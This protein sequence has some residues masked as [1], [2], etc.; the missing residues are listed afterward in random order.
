[1]MPLRQVMAEISRL[2]NARIVWLSGEGQEEQ[3]SV[4]FTDLPLVEG[5]QRILQQK[6]FILFYE[7]RSTGA[8]VTQIW[9]SSDRNAAQPQVPQEAP[10][11]VSPLKRAETGT[12]QNGPATASDGTVMQSVM[13]MGLS[14]PDPSTRANAAVYLGAH[15]GED[16]QARE[17]LEQI[18]RNDTNVRVRKAATEALQ[19]IE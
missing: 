7:Q 6:N 10:V 2:N 12:E 8:Q 1:M 13:Q 4:Q 16:P 15:I 17:T 18:G 3:V 5:L 19:Q 11:K 14:D 9:I